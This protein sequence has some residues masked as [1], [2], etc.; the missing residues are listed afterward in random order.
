MHK[1]AII[2]RQL[3]AGHVG[4]SP[5]LNNHLMQIIIFQYIWRWAYTAVSEWGV[6]GGVLLI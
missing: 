1:Q 6:G 5:H 4:G 3:F 2:C